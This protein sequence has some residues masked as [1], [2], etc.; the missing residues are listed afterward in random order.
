MKTTSQTADVEKLVGATDQS[1]MKDSS[2][3]VENISELSH[4]DF[5]RPISAPQ[6]S[7]IDAIRT[8]ISPKLETLKDPMKVQ[9]GPKHLLSALHDI[10]NNSAND[11]SQRSNK[12]RTAS[13]ELFTYPLENITVPET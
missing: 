11:V 13:E 3:L 12:M 6:S 7:P 8:M 10:I 2:S 1:Q 4:F 5:R 9:E